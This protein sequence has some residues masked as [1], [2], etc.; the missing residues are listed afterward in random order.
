MNAV[1]NTRREAIET[2]YKRD[3]TTLGGAFNFHSPIE[4]LLIRRGGARVWINDVEETV[5]ENELTIA[6]SFDT[7]RYQSLCEGT[8]TVLFISPTMCPAFMEAVR[9]KSAH[10]PVVRDKRTVERIVS[11]VDALSD[12]GMHA[13]EQMGYI[14]VILGA[15]LAQLDLESAKP[16]GNEALPTRL[17]FYINEHYREDLT[18]D[19]IAQALGYD[20]Y[21]LSKRF[22][23]SFRMSMMQYVNT[24]RLKNAVMMMRD[25]GNSITKCAMESGFGSMRTFYR[26]FEEEFGCSPLE[27]LK[28]NRR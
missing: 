4:L 10:N 15:L 12:E 22:R 28:S 17:F 27:Y 18:T 24:L 23:A 2:F 14:N 26:A 6:L 13:I 19:K 3:Y 1:F 25:R 9:Y 21:Y 20:R 8:Y 7:H 16:S 11:A 5:C